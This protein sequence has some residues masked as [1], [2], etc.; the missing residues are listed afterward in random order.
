MA[1]DERPFNPA[2]HRTSGRV[3][4]FLRGEI[5]HSN[6]NSR[7]ECTV[8]DISEG[9]ARI[10]A[11]ASVTLPEFFE[12]LIPLKNARHRAR[13]TWRAGNEIGVSFITEAA[14]PT[15]VT[16]AAEAHAALQ[17]KEVRG[18]L[19]ELEVETT[20]L[21]AQLAQMQNIIDTLVKERGVA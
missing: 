6:G 21:R 13:M 11:P 10:E 4:A 18:R 5:I 14:R 20:R 8:R 3:R 1:Q 7:T 16:T 12:L 9:G 19:Q 15:P 2:D 17:D